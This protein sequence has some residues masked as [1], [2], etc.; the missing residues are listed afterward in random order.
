[1]AIKTAQRSHS[2]LADQSWINLKWS[3]WNAQEAVGTGISAHYDTPTKID[4]RTPIMITLTQVRTCQTQ[5][6]ARIYSH[7]E[8]THK[9][10]HIREHAAWS[11][12]C[13]GRGSAGGG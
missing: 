10:G 12:N 8:L 4:M 13:V 3:Q 1:M 9:V 2:I 5:P 7:I 6:T 11:Y